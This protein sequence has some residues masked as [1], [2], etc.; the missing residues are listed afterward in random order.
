MTE[1]IFLM[2]G[3]GFGWLLGRGLRLREAARREPQ[4]EELPPAVR[5]KRRELEQF[6]RFDG[7]DRREEGRDHAILP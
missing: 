7:Y 6:L 4:P 3:L 2:L 5:R 1:L